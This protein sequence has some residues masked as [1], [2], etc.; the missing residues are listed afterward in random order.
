MN[1]DR[2]DDPEV[3]SSFKVKPS[4]VLKVSVSMESTM[5]ILR[6]GDRIM[7]NFIAE[8]TPPN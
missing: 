3:G 8:E 6:K 5:R 2:I 4:I 1:R 7:I